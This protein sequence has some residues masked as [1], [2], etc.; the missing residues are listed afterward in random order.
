MFFDVTRIHLCAGTGGN[1]VIAFRRE[2]GVPRGGPSGGSGGRGGNVT[3]LAKDGLNTLSS[4][5][6]GRTFRA[7][8]G[9]NGL[10]KSK[11]GEW[12]SSITVNVPAGT[13]VRDDHGKLLADLSEPGH[14]FAAAKGGRGGRGNLAFK[15]DKNRAPR[16]CERGEPGVDRWLR[17][18][19]K[20]VADVA[21]V[22]CPNA[23]KSSLLDAVS[24]AR[25]KIADYP[26]TTV[27]PN[28]GVVDAVDGA[29]GLVLADVPGLIEGAHRG[30]GMG[31]AFL[32]HVERCRVVVHVV[33]ASLET[34]EI[35]L[36]YLRIRREM[37][38][39]DQ[40]LSRKIEVVL[41]NKVDLPGVRERWEN[42]LK[43]ALVQAIDTHKRVALVS[44][45]SGEGL[46][47]VMRKLVHVVNSANDDDNVI[48]LGDEDEPEDDGV[49]VEQL[50]KGVFEVRGWKV[51]KYY[52]MTNFAYVEGVDR[53]QRILKAIGVNE[54]LAQA[55]AIDGNTVRCMDGEFDYYAEENIYS[56]AAALDGYI[57]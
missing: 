53:F 8:D 20:L 54:R 28:V 23:G 3:F 2:K 33:D 27:I 49:I 52:G 43:D 7:D 14:T 18:E 16:L 19:L 51:A 10:G 56:A 38:L 4:L 29:Q 13:V 42:E 44:A 25:P 39:F 15:T 35:I 41:V 6:H 47:R 50:E 26:F 24:S 30:V 46:E 31:V 32:R 57:D 55:G 22:G 12:A 34:E 5:R 11:H 21:L 9:A 45:K 17:L 36:R 40:R 37:H 48:V 1:G